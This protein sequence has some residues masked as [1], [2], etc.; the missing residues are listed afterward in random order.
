MICQ[1]WNI[2][3]GFATL[4]LA[5]ATLFAG[6][7]VIVGALV[8]WRSVQ[9]QISSAE[10][11]ERR[12]YANDVSATKTGFTSELIVYSRGVIEATAL[13]N[14]R[15]AEM[16]GQRI[17]TGWPILQDP[18]FYRANISK[19][20]VLPEQWVALALIGFYANV[21]ELNDQ[22]RE[23]MAGR[24]TVNATTESIAGRLHIMASNLSQ[25]LDGL[26]DDRKFPL[27]PEISLND[28]IMPDGTPL[29]QATNVPQNLQEV[30]LRLAGITAVRP[31]EPIRA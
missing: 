28:L 19:I 8:A 30:L 20:G 26:N 3:E 2:P 25:A 1:M 6:A 31:A 27:Q 23:S 14:R 10:T 18:I 21:L 29:S 4:L 13:W 12:R 15:L 5:L 17:I 22:A 24:P 16:P 11:I 9:R 7:F